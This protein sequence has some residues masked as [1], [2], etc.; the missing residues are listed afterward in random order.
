[1]FVNIMKIEA[2]QLGVKD[3]RNIKKRLRMSTKRQW[4]NK[5]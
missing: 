2:H 4:K 5:N 3:K 1:M